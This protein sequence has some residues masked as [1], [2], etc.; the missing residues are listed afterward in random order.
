MEVLNL[1]MISTQP[2]MNALGTMAHLAAA[3]VFLC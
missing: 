3:P 1:V 2:M